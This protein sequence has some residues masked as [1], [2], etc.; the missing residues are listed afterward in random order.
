MPAARLT[1][2]QKASWADKL[3][4]L[5]RLAEASG[6]GHKPECARET[7]NRLVIID[8]VDVG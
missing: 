3:D 7:M 2:V 1:L 8:G 6:K 5:G 4:V